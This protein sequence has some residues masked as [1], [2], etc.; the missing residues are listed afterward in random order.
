MALHAHHRGVFRDT[1]LTK[2]YPQWPTLTSAEF[3]EL[4]KSARDRYQNHPTH[5]GRTVSDAYIVMARAVLVDGA[6]YR[7]AAE[8]SQ[9]PMN[10]S[11][12]AAE[13]VRTILRQRMLSLPTGEFDRLV[14]Q[15]TQV[16]Q[17]RGDTRISEQAIA[18]A[19]AVLTGGMRYGEAARRFSDERRRLSSTSVDY[20]VQLMLI[21]RTYDCPSW[22]ALETTDSSEPHAESDS[23][24]SR[25]T[26][27]G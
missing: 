27:P 2:H 26:P 15:W 22:T 23:K 5:V 6:T 8:L 18:A 11:N 10:G 17:A 3:D 13:A 25:L 14:D 12:R 20:A 19:R 9:S 1:L 7:E 16:R 4:A 24:A 21:F